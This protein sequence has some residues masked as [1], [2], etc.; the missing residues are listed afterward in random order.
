MIAKFQWMDKKTYLKFEVGRDKAGYIDE[1]S[2]ES[3]NMTLHID[4]GNITL[5]KA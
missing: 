2:V 5:N 3:C 4:K 1:L